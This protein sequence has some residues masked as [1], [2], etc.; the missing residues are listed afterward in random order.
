MKQTTLKTACG[1]L[2]IVFFLTNCSSNSA[3]ENPEFTL[4]IRHN[5]TG[6]R[7][8]FSQIS[9]P[10][11]VFDVSSKQQSF[12]LD[13]GMPEGVNN[14]RVSLTYNCSVNNRTITSDVTV[15]FFE[16][17]RTVIE[18]NRIV[19]CVPEFIILYE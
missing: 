6:D 5:V 12:A 17:K 3:D 7:I 11:Y 15:N 18:I 2:F 16:D 13:E 9:L 8:T 4:V 1:I 14:I 10:G 19:T